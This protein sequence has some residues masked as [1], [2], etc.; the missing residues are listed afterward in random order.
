MQA[1]RELTC[2]VYSFGLVTRRL[3]RWR[4]RFC[5]PPTQL[6]R[7]WIHRSVAPRCYA[8]GARV[9]PGGAA[10]VVVYEVDEPR[11]EID[12][13]LP[14]GRQRRRRCN[15]GVVGLS[16]LGMLG[17]YPRPYRGLC[18]GV[19]RL[20]LGLYLGADIGEP[21]TSVVED[22]HLDST[23]RGHGHTVDSHGS[24]VSRQSRS[25]TPSSRPGLRG[26]FARST[27]WVAQIA[28]L[29]AARRQGPLWWRSCSSLALA[30]RRRGAP[31]V[32]GRWCALRR[33][34][35]AA[36]AGQL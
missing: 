17:E 13:C 19:Q 34:R 11:G 14:P 25:T 12:S 3:R 18:L 24:L 27:A 15:L 6:R 33:S 32:P 10:S 36:Q 7:R 22:E 31:G 26:K 20:I 5:A 35:R 2:R 4:T 21:L 16:R 23:D 28:A 30:G 8:P 9:G 1:R 29:E